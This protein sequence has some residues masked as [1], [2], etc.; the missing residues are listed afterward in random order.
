MICFEA[1]RFLAGRIFHPLNRINNCIT[2][3]TFGLMVAF[4]I[5]PV[6]PAKIQLYFAPL[7]AIVDISWTSGNAILKDF[8]V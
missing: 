2:G 5:N 7:Y 6:A 1:L 8:L 3:S 4:V